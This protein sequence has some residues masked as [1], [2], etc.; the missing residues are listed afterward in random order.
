MRSGVRY[1]LVMPAAGSSRRF[2]TQTLKQYAPLAGS[3]VLECALTPFLADERCSAV[4]L[5][6]ARA[7]PERARLARWL[8]ARGRIV[9][10]GA[11]RCESVL[12]GLASLEGSVEV[13]AWVLVHDA[14][15]PCITDADIER[16]IG[17]VAGHGSATPGV[18]GG[19]LAVPL[20]DTLKRADADALCLE[21]PSRN[22]LWC[23]QTPQ[24]YRLGALRAALEQ[25]QAMGRVP[26]DEA[27]AMEWAGVR[28]RLVAAEYCNLKVTTA[29]DLTLA[30]AVLAARSAGGHA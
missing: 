3:T 9:D 10:G 8:G 11:E 5:V 20:A 21:T 13:T 17:T 23:A 12:N 14:A 24:M 30:A 1:A 16:L 18:G 26:T 27:Q 25:A 19:L 22:G 6:L 2:D 28:S 15:R 7:D 4:R 29:A